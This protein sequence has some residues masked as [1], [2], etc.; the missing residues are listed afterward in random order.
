MLHLDQ[1]GEAIQLPLLETRGQPQAVL[2]RYSLVR[3][4]LELGVLLCHPLHL[5]RAEVPDNFFGDCLSS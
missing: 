3:A 1:L 4:R 2:H 5:R